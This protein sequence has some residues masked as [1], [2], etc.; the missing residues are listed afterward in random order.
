MNRQRPLK[1]PKEFELAG[2]I[3][4]VF[5]DGLSCLQGRGGYQLRGNAVFTSVAL[6][7]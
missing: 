1:N 5:E 6:N 2:R 4:F 7:R 3:G